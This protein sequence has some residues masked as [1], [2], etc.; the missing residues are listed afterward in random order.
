MTNSMNNISADISKNGQKLH[1]LR[2]A[3]S[4]L[5]DYNLAWGL[6]VQTRCDELDLISRSHVC[7]NHNLQFFLDSCPLYKRCMVAAHMNMIKHSMLCVTGEY[8][9]DITNTYFLQVCT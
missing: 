4:T 3:F 5:H 8:L 9:R 7:Q 1:C 2:E 6:A